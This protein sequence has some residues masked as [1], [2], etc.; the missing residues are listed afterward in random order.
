MVGLTSPIIKQWINEL[1][2]WSGGSTL[3]YLIV[4]ALGICERLR[5]NR[6]Q[7]D[8]E[9]NEE[10]FNTSQFCLRKSFVLLFST[11][12]LLPSRINR[13]NPGVLQPGQMGEGSQAQ[14]AR[15]STHLICGCRSNSLLRL[16]VNIQKRCN[17]KQKALRRI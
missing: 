10:I 12:L 11:A 3:Y 13:I 9:K 8:N 16:R 6:C 17:F 7:K 1:I 14:R 15:T 4:G 2:L 5:K